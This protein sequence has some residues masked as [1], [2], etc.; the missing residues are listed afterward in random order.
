MEWISVET[1]LPEDG[2]EVLIN[3]AEGVE[4]AAYH[5]AEPDQN[6]VM[7]HDAGFIG[8]KFAFPS[9]SFGV[10]TY[11]RKAQGQPTHWMPLPPPPNS[12]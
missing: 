7:G 12:K 10:D 3:G 8:Y 1:K 9:R 11:R 6:D 5:P 2:V 4:V